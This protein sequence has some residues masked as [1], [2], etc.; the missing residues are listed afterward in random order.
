MPMIPQAAVAMLACQRIGAIHSVVFGGF[1]APELAFRIRDVQA[2]LVIS[3]S[4][5]VEVNKRVD[6][7]RILKEALKMSE[8]ELKT[9]VYARDKEKT[10]YYDYQ[11][12]IDNNDPIDCV[13]V[14]G[15][16]PSYVLYTS[17]T[18]G[19]PK[20]V[21]R[22]QA[23]MAAAL[24]YS[25]EKVFGVGRRETIFAASDI[26]WVVGHSYVVY[27]PLIAG[28]A[29]VIFEGKPIGTPDAGIYWKIV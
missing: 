19:H 15:S 17:G 6:Y 4:Y 16:H 27:G 2:K 21:V 9:I 8:S 3:T 10:S 29:G 12:V 26:G 22:D 23:G 18:T 13:P 11:S 1:A 20:G 28:A 24:S 14:T 25:M 7:L 5:G